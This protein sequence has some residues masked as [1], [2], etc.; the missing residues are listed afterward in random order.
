MCGVCGSYFV[1]EA[2]G[3]LFPCDFYCKD[4][5]KL[6]SIFDENPFEMN[7][8]QRDFIERSHIIHKNCGTCKYHILCRGGCR[9]D[10]TDEYTKKQILRGV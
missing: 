6:G 10:R 9:R 5:Y 7:D 3:D 4:E 8:K 1:V 2:N